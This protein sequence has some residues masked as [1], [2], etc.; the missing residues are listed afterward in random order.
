M[1]G[2]ISFSVILGS[3]DSYLTHIQEVVGFRL[4][5]IHTPENDEAMQIAISLISGEEVA[6]AREAGSDVKALLDLDARALRPLQASARTRVRAI[7]PEK[8][9]GVAF[10]V[11]MGRGNCERERPRLKTGCATTCLESSR[12]GDAPERASSSIRREA[13]REVPVPRV[14]GFRSSLD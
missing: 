4:S 14:Y 10:E 1:R 5:F 2:N 9:L 13:A 12:F 6:T 8:E 11:L 7:I 3:F